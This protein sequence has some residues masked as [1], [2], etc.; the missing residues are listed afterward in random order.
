MKILVIDDEEMIRSL[1]E[2]VLRRGGYEVLSVESGE[3]AVQAMNRES[4]IAGVLLD[5]NLPGMSGL[6]TLRRLRDIRA[7]VPCV[8]SSGDPE[9]TVEI[10]ESL[11]MR[12]SYLEKP[13]R[14]QTL[15]QTID[16]LLK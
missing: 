11:R 7:D 4:D 13:Y 2:K 1:A 5:M 10:D 16:S 14:A 6:E 8:L 12:T 3:H 9:G 15:I